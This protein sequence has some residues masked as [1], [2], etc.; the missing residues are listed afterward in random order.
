VPTTVDQVR[1]AEA[2]HADQPVD[3]R[4]EDRSLVLL[5]RLLER[6]AAES[7]PCVV[8]EDVEA[9]ELGGRALHE[10]LAA[11]GIRYVELERDVGVDRVDAAR[12]SGHARA[13]LA[14]IAHCRSADPARRARDDRG[15]PPD[16]C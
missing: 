8:D 4:I 11:R 12:S 13:R 2:R 16:A 14:E 10:R 15:L 9:A 6:I 1:E 3:V 5:R 7:E